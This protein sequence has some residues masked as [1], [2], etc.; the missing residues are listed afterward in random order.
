MTEATWKIV[1]RSNREPS[2]K[3]G[4][5]SFDNEEHFYRRIEEIKA[6]HWLTFINGILPNGQVITK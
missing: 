3:E 4:T 2:A 5:E 1:V 6:D